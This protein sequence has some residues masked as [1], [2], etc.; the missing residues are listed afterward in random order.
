MDMLPD[1]PSNSSDLIPCSPRPKLVILGSLIVI[2]IDVPPDSPPPTQILRSPP[3]ASQ[4]QKSPMAIPRDSFKIHP[5]DTASDIPK[6][7]DSVYAHGYPHIYPFKSQTPPDSEFPAPIVTD[8]LVFRNISMQIHPPRHSAAHP[9]SYRA[10]VFPMLFP[11]ICF[12]IH[13][14][15]LPPRYSRSVSSNSLF[16]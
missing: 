9:Q 13:P 16:F 15:P 1:L 8:A 10:G 12:Q 3:P 5:R 6:V 2:P 4:I 7:A 11:K 14:P